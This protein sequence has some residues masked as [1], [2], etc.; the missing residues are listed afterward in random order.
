M[1]LLD[2]IQLCNHR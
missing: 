2:P 1:H